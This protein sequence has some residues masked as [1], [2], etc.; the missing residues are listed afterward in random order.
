MTVSVPSH[1][2]TSVSEASG[3]LN[4]NRAILSA[5]T[6]LEAAN[7]NLAH[8]I[9]R[10]ERGANN[11]S[12]PVQSPRPIETVS[13]NLPQG[14]RWG[15]DSSPIANQRTHSQVSHG[16]GGRELPVTHQSLPNASHT[17]FSHSL[18]HSAPT[19]HT[20][21]MEASRDTII[22]SV[23]AVR[24][25]PSISSAVSRLLAQYEDQ[26]HQD[27]VPGKD[28]IRKKSGHYNTT[29]TCNT[30]PELS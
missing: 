2:Y 25:I 20:E 3:V 30:K 14:S 24:S 1:T 18:S 12:T 29:D 27:I 26:T 9:E 19:G 21:A 16:C 8:R 22:P 23:D 11:N 17:D 28:F 5:L 4:P 13:F 10:M 7:Q 6:R 15:R